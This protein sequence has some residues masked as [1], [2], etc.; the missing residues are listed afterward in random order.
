MSIEPVFVGA[1]PGCVLSGGARA[2]VWVADWSIHGPGHV[3]IVAYENETAVV[4]REPEL[5]RWLAN[6]LTAYFPEFEG[7]DF[8]KARY[9]DGD[10]EVQ[11]LTSTGVRATFGG[12]E[13][14]IGD[15]KEVRPVT[16]DTWEMG[17]NTM[18]LTNLL[19]PSQGGEYQQGRQAVRGRADHRLRRHQRAVG[20]G[21]AGL[22]A[23]RRT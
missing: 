17:A 2:S 15:S 11:L 10:V 7:V 5:A 14:Q 3:G 23:I 4:S 1:N 12:F 13:V 9:I 18:R 20:S 21:Q 19:S 22:G 8:G 16:V 6:E